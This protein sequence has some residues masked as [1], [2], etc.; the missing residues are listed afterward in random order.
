MGNPGSG[1]DP[2]IPDFLLFSLQGG[3]TDDKSDDGKSNGKSVS[4]LSFGVNR[5]TISCIFDCKDPRGAGKAFPILFLE[6]DGKRKLGKGWRG[7]WCL[8]EHP[9]GLGL[10][11]GISWGGLSWDSLRWETGIDGKAFLDSSFP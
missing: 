10:V 1:G 9:Q 11:L 8:W 2:G 3:V 5:P 6:K 7:G 4:T